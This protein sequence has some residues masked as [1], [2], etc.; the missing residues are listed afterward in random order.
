[1]ET[2]T[3]KL[4]KLKSNTGQ[5]AGL[6]KN[7]RFIKDE[8]FE[9]LVKSIKDDPEMLSLREVIAYDN[10]SELV[11]IAGNMRLKAC[12]E[13]GIKE[14]PCKILPN[15][16]P[17]EKL[18]AYTIKDNV[19]FGEH[20]FDLLLADWDPGELD[21]WGIDMPKVELNLEAEDDNFVGTV[22]KDPIT[23]S[24][25][26]YEIGHHRLLCASST[27][28]DSFVNL[29]AGEMADMVVTD[30]PYN[31]NYEGG[32]GLKIMNDS[33]SDGNFYQFLYDFYTALNTVVRP[34]GAWY[35][36][37][38]DSEGA[39]FRKAMTDAGIL[40][41]QCLIWVKSSIVLGRQ[42]YHWKHKPCLEGATNGT[43]DMEP[44]EDP[45]TEII[46]THVPILYGWKE[47]AAHKWR[48]DRKQSTV[49]EFDKPTKNGE[50]PTMKPVELIGYQIK[51]NSDENDI[52]ADGFL[53]SGTTMVAAHQLNRRCYGNELD[54]KYC[55]VIV[56]RMIKVAPGIT[57][58]RNGV[59]LA[60]DER[61]KFTNN[62]NS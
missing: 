32:T 38:A 29:M 54:P 27:E 45:N 61:E 49:L 3:V 12:K 46:K 43:P 60:A 14:V 1:M 41:K 2:K 5:V 35:V 17:L 19:S 39:N 56:A 59:E 33:M 10:G 13:L 31:V 48:S 36:W 52:V 15:D 21:D 24:G 20:D 58:F 55:D 57:I 34:G 62:T 30:P 53:G 18:K 8:K 9:K 11:V 37:H 22:P 6:P 47:G 42:D 28:T 25:D 16:T 51:N 40:L 23:V 4:A 7:P 50:H 44:F 26:L